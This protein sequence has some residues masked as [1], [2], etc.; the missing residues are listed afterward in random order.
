M[1]K[2]FHLKRPSQSWWALLLAVLHERPMAQGVGIDCSA[3]ALAVAQGNAQG[4]GLEARATMR[5]ADWTQDGWAQDLGRFDLILSNPPYVEQDADLAPSVRGYEPAGALFAGADGLDDYRRLIPQLPALLTPDGIAVLEIGHTQAEA[6][7]A[8]A[9]QAGFAA[10]L[11]RDL[12]G[13]PRAVAL[14]WKIE[15][16]D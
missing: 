10:R 4:L 9:A 1:R 6:V 5:L 14:S 16:R 12:A 8:L 2:N 7:A 3:A 13:R 15:G 11:H